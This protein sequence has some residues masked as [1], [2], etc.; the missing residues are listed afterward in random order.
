M[1]SSL[2]VI[3]VA[4]CLRSALSTPLFANVS[5][6]SSLTLSPIL[7]NTGSLFVM[8]MQSSPPSPCPRTPFPH[9]HLR[10]RSLA[11]DTRVLT[12]F[13]TPMLVDPN[14]LPIT[15]HPLPRVPLRRPFTHSSTT[16]PLTSHHTSAE[17]LS[18]CP[19]LA[20]LCLPRVNNCP[21]CMTTLSTPACSL[22]CHSGFGGETICP[23]DPGDASL[24]MS[25]GDVEA[26]AE[27]SAFFALCLIGHLHPS[28]YH[29]PHSNLRSMTVFLD[30]APLLP[31]PH[32]QTGTGRRRSRA[33]GMSQESMEVDDED[34][35]RAS[36]SARDV[37]DSEVSL[38][39]F[40]LCS[41]RCSA[42]RR[43]RC[44]FLKPLRKAITGGARPM[45]DQTIKDTLKALRD[46]LTEKAGVI[47]RESA[48]VR[49]NNLG[50]ELAGSLSETD[51]RP[52]L[53]V[54]PPRS[55]GCTQHFHHP[56]RHGQPHLPVPPGTREC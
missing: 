40:L 10:H 55:R 23:L 31:R 37:E 19:S 26:L 11:P 39:L 44:F 3:M 38:F 43:W 14:L 16:P 18:P 47:V 4:F 1:I 13:A 33:R 7:V 50:R 27:S 45:S 15:S 49:R 30:L 32:L 5:L 17:P 22:V 46:G 36:A 48:D 28:I 56:L 24:D 2:S 29:L 41:V 9:P 34:G 53:H 25:A 6:A 54:V 21:Y 8:S 52:P 42:M 12:P 20:S 35:A 51:T